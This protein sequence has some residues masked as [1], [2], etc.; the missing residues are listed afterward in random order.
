MKDPDN[1]EEAD[2]GRRLIYHYER[3]YNRNSLHKDYVKAQRYAI[4]N[5]EAWLTERRKSWVV[6]RNNANSGNTI[7]MTKIYAVFPDKNKRIRISEKRRFTKEDKYPRLM[8]FF[9]FDMKISWI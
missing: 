2:D 1:N 5:T 4:P 8:M 3:A 9:I 6:M 7:K